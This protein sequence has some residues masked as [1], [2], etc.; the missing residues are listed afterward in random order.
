M[1]SHDL[2]KCW[3]FTNTIPKNCREQKI[4]IWNFSFQKFPIVVILCI[5]HFF[6]N[7][8]HVSMWWHIF[9]CGLSIPVAGKIKECICFTAFQSKWDCFHTKAASIYVNSI[10]SQRFSS[11]IFLCICERRYCGAFHGTWL[12]IPLWYLWK[13]NDCI[14]LGTDVRRIQRKSAER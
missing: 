14:K 12:R 9:V 13:L 4:K 7:M 5:A 1:P 2:G 10:R 3:L 6:V 11:Q 8:A